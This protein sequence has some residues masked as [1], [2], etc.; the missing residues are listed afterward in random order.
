M[1]RTVETE[2]ERLRRVIL[3]GE[4]V[5]ATGDSTRKTAQYFTKT[6]FSIS[7]CTVSDY[8]ARYCKMRPEEVDI[9]RGKIDENVVRDV[10][11]EEIRKRVSTVAELFESGMT[12]QQIADMM[13]VKFW[14][15]YRDIH[16]RLPLIDAALYEEKI[17]PL[18][19][20]HSTK[21][22]RNYGK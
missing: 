3:V 5:L 15:V 14:V 13:N 16:T 2:E 1:A 17:K 21:N 12:I 8:C 4:H 9:L 7:N 18:L 19:P 20:E 22:L 11:D 6:Y 10:K